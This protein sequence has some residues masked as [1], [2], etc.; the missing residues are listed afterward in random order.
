MEWAHWARDSLRSSLAVAAYRVMGLPVRLGVLF[1]DMESRF[2]CRFP[3]TPL[4]E[5]VFALAAFAISSL[6]M[7]LLGLAVFQGFPSWAAVL[8]P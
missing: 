6:I 2:E 8:H 4:E 1:P 7:P 3:N 5:G